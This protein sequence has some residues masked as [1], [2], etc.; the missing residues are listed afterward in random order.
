MKLITTLILTLITTLTFAQEGETSKTPTNQKV[1]YNRD[2]EFPGGQ[3]AM[4]MFITENMRYPKESVDNNEQAMI[5]IMYTVEAD[6]TL[7]N[8]RAGS[9][10]TPR[11]AEEAVRIFSIMPKWDSAI[12]NGNTIKQ[13][14]FSTINFQL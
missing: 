6:G 8:I 10:T 5:S 4:D 14:L 11:L 9:N 13:S 1:I 7:S 12:M 3:A 2:A